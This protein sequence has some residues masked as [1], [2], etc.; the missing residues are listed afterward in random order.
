MK[1]LLDH[2]SLLH[3]LSSTVG[4]ILQIVQQG[5]P[6][7]RNRI[8]G[9]KANSIDSLEFLPQLRLDH[10]SGNTKC[11]RGNIEALSCDLDTG[12]GSDGCNTA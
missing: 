5:S 2:G 3:L 4:R 10:V 6:I 11:I 1:D 7:T 9:R 8:R 12:L